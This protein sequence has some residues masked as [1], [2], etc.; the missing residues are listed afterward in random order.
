MRVFRVGSSGFSLIELLIAA[1]LTSLLLVAAISTVFKFNQSWSQSRSQL[2][3]RRNLR[4]SLS[5]MVHDLRMAGSGFG[6]LPAVTPGVAEN[7]VYP[8]EPHSN[9]GSLDT[10]VVTGN[11]GGASS[12]TSSVM[13]SPSAPLL[14]VNASEFA[15]GDLVVISDG[16]SANLLEVTSVNVGAGSLEHSADS[17]WNTPEG[18]VTWP[19]GGYPPGSAVVHAERIRYWIDRDAPVHQLLRQAHG[20]SPVV[21]ADGIEGLQVLFNMADGSTARTPP[22]PSLVRSVN[23]RCLISRPQH[24]GDTYEAGFDTTTTIIQPRVIG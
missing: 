14:V 6:G 15:A 3:N 12:V 7:V 4:A 24:A 8:I 2:G 21:I 13:A 5:L 20:E 16:N 10:L 19:A 9:G 11:L 23:L 18:H 1:T 17:P 22:D